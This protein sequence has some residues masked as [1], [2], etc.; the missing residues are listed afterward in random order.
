MPR[1]LLFLVV[2]VMSATA[3]AAAL[4]KQTSPWWG[5]IKVLAGDDLQGRLT[6]T[7]S[8]RKAAEY[9]AQTFERAGLTPAPARRQPMAGP[10]RKRRD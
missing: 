2:C 9:V 10:N 5:H 7:P 8:Y 6:G 4:D 3:H 1:L